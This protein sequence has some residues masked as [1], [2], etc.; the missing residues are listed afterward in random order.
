MGVG[1]HNRQ[2]L[3]KAL[4]AGKYLNIWKDANM[5]VVWR[6]LQILV[7]TLELPLEPLILQ[8]VGSASSDFMFLSTET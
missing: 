8:E 5:H 3:R 1:L 7:V 4:K 2:F 6:H